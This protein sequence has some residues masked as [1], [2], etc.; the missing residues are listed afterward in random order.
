[1]AN[2]SLKLPESLLAEVRA[3]AERQGISSSSV[4]RE[5]VAAYLTHAATPRPGSFAELARDLAG[6]VAGPADLSHNP[7][8]LD[9]YGR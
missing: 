6:C 7:V 5:A 4:I 9:G 8:H 3:L 1:M 2:L